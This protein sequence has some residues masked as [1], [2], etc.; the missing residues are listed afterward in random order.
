MASASKTRWP[1]E[2]EEYRRA[3][4]AAEARRRLTVA[5]RDADQRHFGSE[6]EILARRHTLYQRAQ[7]ANPSR[8][9]GAVRDRLSDDTEIQPDVSVV[10]VRED[11]YRASHPSAA[12]VRLLVE[13]SDSTLLYDREVKVSLYARCGIQA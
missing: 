12:D 7:R 3:R 4:T 6:H 10:R 13:V 11:Y 2:S 1:N 8:W 5:A 9:S